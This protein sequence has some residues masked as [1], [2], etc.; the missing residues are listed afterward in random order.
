MTIELGFR[1][2]ATNVFT[3]T[4]AF[5]KSVDR[6]T[7][8]LF[9]SIPVIASGTN[10]IDVSTNYSVVGYGY[11]RLATINNANT[12]VASALSNLTVRVGQKQP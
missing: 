3:N 4:F 2:G 1:C 7:W 10:R 5:E 6:S 11:L 8:Y 9:Q 12:N